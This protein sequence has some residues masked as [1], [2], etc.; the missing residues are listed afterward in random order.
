MLAPTAAIP[1]GMAKANVEHIPIGIIHAQFIQASGRHMHSQQPTTK[2]IGS[3]TASIHIQGISEIRGINID[4]R[5]E[6]RAQGYKHIKPSTGKQEPQGIQEVMPTHIST[7][8]EVR[9]NE[10]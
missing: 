10:K 5:E 6:M 9:I 2:W 3:I 4:E 1:Q 7:H 8:Q